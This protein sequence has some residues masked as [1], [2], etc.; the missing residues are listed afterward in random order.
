MSRDLRIEKLTRQGIALMQEERD[1]ATSGAL[2]RLEELNVRKADF[3]DKM[4]ALA[5]QIDAGGPTQLQE[6]RRQ[7]I[8]TLF[9]IIRRRAEE[10]SIILK[11]AEAGVKSAQRRV[12]VIFAASEF[13]GA[14]TPNGEPISASKNTGKTDATF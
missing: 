10:N 8:A 14:Y 11:A 12:G 3:M 7:E 4:T 5:A 13:I 6:A 9:D 2:E 1:A